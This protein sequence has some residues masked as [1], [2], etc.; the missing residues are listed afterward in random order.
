MCLQCYAATGDVTSLQIGVKVI[1]SRVCLPKWR[2]D[3][4]FFGSCL[5]L[6]PCDLSDPRL[7]RGFVDVFAQRQGDILIADGEALLLSTVVG[8]GSV[9]AA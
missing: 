3:S 4:T 9:V 1:N 2:N 8:S 5:D 7:Q 6:V